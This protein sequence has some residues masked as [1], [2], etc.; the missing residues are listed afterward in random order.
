MSDAVSEA[1]RPYRRKLI[2]TSIPLEDINR[3]SIKEKSIRYGH[4]STLHQWWA[5]RPLAACRAV[6]FAQLVDDPSGCPGLSEDEQERRRKDLHGIMSELAKWEN[7]NNQQ[8]LAKA[9]EEIRLSC[10]G[11]PPPILDPFVGGGSIPLEA[12][13]L[14]LDAYASDLNPVAVLISKAVIEIPH[15]W[16]GRPPTF[17]G[18]AGPARQWST[19]KGLAEDVRCYGAWMRDEA[20]RR[21]GHLY[22]KAKLGDGTLASVIAWIWAR[23]VTC[24]NP[25]CGGTMPLVR[26]FW[27]GKKKGKERYVEP[28]PE[29]NRVR[30][31]IRGLHGAP[32]E[33]TVGRNGAT[34]LVCETPVPLAYIRAEGQAGRMGAQ[35]MAIAAEGRRQRYYLPASDEHEKAADVLRPEDVP[36]AEIPYNPRYLTAPNYGM[37]T[38]ADLFTS[39][40]LT[41][42]S[43]FS[44]M[45]R[46]AHARIIND[47]AEP[48]YADA[49]T[50]YL[51]LAVSRIVSTNSALCRW[52]PDAAKESVN[53]TFGRQALPM[54]WDFAEGCPFTVGPPAFSWSISWVTR[55]LENLPGRAY[56]SAIQ[57]DARNAQYD[58]K[59]IVATDPPYYDNIGYA[60][61]ADFFYVWLRRSLKEIYP[62]L[63]ETILSPK[64]DEIVADPFRHGGKEQAQ[65]FFEERFET[66]FSRIR[67][68]APD[69]YP[70]SFFYAYKQAEVD[71]EGDQSST[72]WE[73]LLKAMLKTGWIVTATWPM[74]TELGSRPRNRESNAL[75]SSI[76]MVC[77]PRPETAEE[78]D[79]RGLI[80]ALRREL[81]G[82]LR[83]LQQANIAP[84]DLEQTAIGPGMAICSRY[85]RVTEADGTRMSVRA[86]LGIINRVLGEAL[87]QQEGDFTPDTRW[88]VEWFKRHGF[89][90]G[91]YDEA[92]L[93]SKAKN[94]TVRGLEGA[95]VVKAYGGKVTL[96]SPKSMAESY[97]PA[98][99]H[100]VSEWKVCLHLAKLLKIVGAQ[101]AARL[102]A[103]AREC[104][105]LDAV[106]ELAYLL[107]SIAE[108]RGSREPAQIFNDL[109]TFWAELNFMSR[110]RILPRNQNSITGIVNQ[111]SSKP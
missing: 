87:A 39:R 46:E 16:A 33:G 102:M 54:V 22:P 94:T 85:R 108:T 98:R 38:W 41:A 101:S 15:K 47:G 82:A 43:T 17:P 76:V 7:I 31:E 63:M 66:V 72:G 50:T 105:D 51:A 58:G 111:R 88:C 32:R 9:R 100:R 37:R 110:G 77:R 1:P 78:I 24:P 60:D 5:R 70:I 73:S 86:E 89:N 104:V 35:L 90:S 67:N 93:L 29:G 23:T 96:L 79:R 80:S 74:R 6:L 61:L 2:E 92:D 13:R 99:D 56:G 57:S 109:G 12:Q 53:D 75:S 3:E 26:S 25:A 4:P 106:K 42:L 14:G 95:G 11:R 103:A 21:I 81:P 64:E 8:L 83:T 27:L 65:Q 48:E 97:D 36:D 45:V 91:P 55:V 68:G 49:V 62:E 44:D 71:N 59:L 28:I 34:C 10:D 84:V 52:R 107:H 18:A 30:F 19:A 40:Q 69:G 20:E